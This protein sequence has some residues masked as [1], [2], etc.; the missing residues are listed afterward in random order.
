MNWYSGLN[1][2]DALLID[3][4]AGLTIGADVAPGSNSIANACLTR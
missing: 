4:K 2:L 3:A 1:Q